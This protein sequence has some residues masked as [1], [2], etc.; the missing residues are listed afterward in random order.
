MRVYD[1]RA[2]DGQLRG[3]EVENLLL[4]RRGVTRVVR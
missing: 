3:F 4:G 2:E 1:S